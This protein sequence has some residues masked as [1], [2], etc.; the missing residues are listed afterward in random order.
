MSQPK[1]ISTP[2]P[3]PASLPSNKEEGTI[4]LNQECAVTLKRWIKELHLTLGKGMKA[5]KK[6]YAKTLITHYES[7]PPRPPTPPPPTSP[8]SAS[9][10]IP[11]KYNAAISETLLHHPSAEVGHLL[12]CLEQHDTVANLPSSPIIRPSSTKSTSNYHPLSSEEATSAMVD[13]KDPKHDIISGTR[14]CFTTNFN[15]TKCRFAHVCAVLLASQEDDDDIVS[16]GKVN[17]LGK[18]NEKDITG[19]E[20]SEEGQLLLDKYVVELK[21][22]CGTDKAFYKLAF[23]K[24]F[25]MKVSY[26]KSEIKR[27]YKA[28]VWSHDVD[29]DYC[30]NKL[31]I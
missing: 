23:K 1:A 14:I 6:N 2:Q 11:E 13:M 10:V 18:L 28:G 12:F 20:V 24:K 16:Q 4:L 9:V 26:F 3:P 8:A 5:N 19:E 17:M 7:N 31:W 27:K 15:Q 30:A 29:N 21:K 25:S 22:V